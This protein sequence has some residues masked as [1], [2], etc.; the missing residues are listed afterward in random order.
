[1]SRPKGS[2]ELIREDLPKPVRG[3]GRHIEHVAALQRGS[4]HTTATP[5]LTCSFPRTRSAPLRSRHGCP[6][7]GTATSLDRCG[8]AVR[9][10][11]V[12][13]FEHDPFAAGELDLMVKDA[14]G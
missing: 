1:M 12:L 13:V 9:A 2:L 11:R 8:R 14:G 4:T 5:S 10:A 7:P 6:Q 3:R